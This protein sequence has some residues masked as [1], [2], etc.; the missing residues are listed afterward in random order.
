MNQQYFSQKMFNPLEKPIQE[1]IEL[2]VKTFQN[3]SYLTP[4]ELFSVVK[5]EEMLER[6]IEMMVKNGHKALDY[7]HNLFSI[8]EKNMLD[9]SGT[10]MTSAQQAIQQASLA[11]QKNMQQ[12]TSTAQH[13]VKKATSVM[14]DVTKKT[15]KKAESVA[16]K[17]KKEATKIM[18]KATKTA[19][20][21]T[22]SAAKPSATKS[23]AKSTKVASRSNATKTEAKSASPSMMEKSSTMNKVATKVH[24]TRQ[25]SPLSV[26]TVTKELEPNKKDRP[27]M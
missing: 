4:V 12:A 16:R 14:K 11:T 7:M 22:K 10:M 15:A 17:T 3:F 9:M 18:R 5:P 8:M 27:L 25:V 20:S 2:H 13:T 26:P 6:N 24:D 1:L 21:V 23:K 19:S